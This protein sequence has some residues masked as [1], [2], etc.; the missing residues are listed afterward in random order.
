MPRYSPLKLMS[1]SKSVIGLNMLT[2]WDAKHSLEE[3]I[4]PL[5]S[6]S[7][8]GAMRPVVAARFPLD[9]GP[10]AHRYLHARE[11]VGKVVLEP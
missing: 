11:N 10:D 9:E 4:A 7:T 2:L 1:Q 8:S 5:R 3:Y 6:G